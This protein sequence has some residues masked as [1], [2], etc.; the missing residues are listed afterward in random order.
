M[1]SR[2]EPIERHIT[3]FDASGEIEIGTGHSVLPPI[4]NLW[5]GVSELIES[6]G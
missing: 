5:T 1:P 3:R 4:T 2:L 6:L